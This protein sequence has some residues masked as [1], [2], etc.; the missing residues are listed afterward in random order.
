MR[1]GETG[2][3]HKDFHVST[4]TTVHFILERY[5]RE[6][7][8][9]LM[10]RTAQ[11]VYRDIYGHLKA[12]DWSAL[13]E[14]WKHFHEREGGESCFT[15]TGTGDALVF[16]VL[17]CPAARHLLD[18]GIEVTDEFR[19]PDIL[20]NEAWSEGTPFLIQTEVIGP[21]EYRQTVTRRRAS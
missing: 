15:Y 10:R 9:E 13:L 11:D 16:H 7:L 6:F 20:M 8:K 12:G 3:I 21:T 1:Y 17:D 18:K 2:E 14:H 4:N 19:L 5:G